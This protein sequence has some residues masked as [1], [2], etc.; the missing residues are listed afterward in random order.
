MK[1]AALLFKNNGFG[2]LMIGFHSYGC[3]FFLL[4]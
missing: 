2:I 1:L 4:S 3:S